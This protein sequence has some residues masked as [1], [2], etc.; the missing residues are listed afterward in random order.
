MKVF[1]FTAHRGSGDY[2]VAVKPGR[3]LPTLSL[4]VASPWRQGDEIDLD[5]C[6]GLA[7]VRVS[8]EEVKAAIARDGVYVCEAHVRVTVKSNV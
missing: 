2:Y 8:M 4:S 5:T 1:A 3:E 6:Q 7:G